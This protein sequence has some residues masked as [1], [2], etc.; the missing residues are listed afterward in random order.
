MKIVKRIV[1]YIVVSFSSI[2]RSP[3]SLSKELETSFLYIKFTFVEWAIHV[4]A[5]R[6]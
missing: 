2:M 4:L 6:C 5:K 1:Y 3:R